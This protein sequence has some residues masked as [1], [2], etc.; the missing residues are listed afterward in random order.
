MTDMR[1]ALIVGSD[2]EAATRLHRKLGPLLAELKCQTVRGPEGTDLL[3]L[4][5]STSFRLIAVA[6]P[7]DRPPLVELLR[8]IRWSESKCRF[9]AVLV[10]GDAA[11]LADA[12]VHRGRGVNRLLAYETPERV[13]R[14]A[15]EELLGVAPRYPIRATIRVEMLTETNDRR[16][17]Q[18]DNVS[19]TGMLVLGRSRYPEGTPFRFEFTPPGQFVPIK[20]NAEV[21]RAT[22]PD[23]EGVVGF[24]ARFTEIDG[25]GRARLEQFL[26]SKEPFR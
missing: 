6:H 22:A 4:V 1:Q 10:V 12:E 14:R 11:S 15:L 19:A 20:G 9:A 23:R 26:R 24:A 7:F 21:V 17:A 16:M 18:I 3:E 13:M 25:D 8:S 2:H 5:Q